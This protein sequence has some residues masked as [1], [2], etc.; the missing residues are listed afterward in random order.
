M[1]AELWLGVMA[2]AGTI[3]SGVISAIISGR[4][5]NYRIKQ[6]EQKV[7]KHNSLITRTYE[8]EGK[9]AII[10]NEIEHLKEEN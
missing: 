3:I 1:T 7:D 2:L 5:V 8:I 10:E 6:L 4:L 9:I